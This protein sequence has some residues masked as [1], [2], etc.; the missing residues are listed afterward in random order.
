MTECERILAEG[1]FPKDFL[2]EEIRNGFLIT[3]K[4]KKNW[5]IQLDIL[6][7]FDDFCKKHNLKYFMLFGSLIGAVRHKGIIPWDDDIDV[8]MIKEDYDKFLKIAPSNFSEPYFV[9]C[10]DTQPNCYN[11][12]SRLNNSNTSLLYLPQLYHDF[13]LGIGIDLFSLEGISN[14]EEGRNLLNQLQD[15]CS[16]NDAA[17]RLETPQDLWLEDQREFQKN[18][19]G[20]DPHER[21]KLI[22]SLREKSHLKNHDYLSTLNFPKSG[23]DR[24]V[25]HREDFN[26]TIYLDFECLPFK[27]PVPIG[28]DRILKKI[29]GDYMR[30]PDERKVRVENPWFIL[31]PDVPYKELLVSVRQKYEKGEPLI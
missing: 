6:I 27:V 23:F 8:A 20:G 3:E 16:L 30:F 25:F 2:K 14:D 31:N 21:L 4:Q 7:K 11:T 12:L 10:N 5:L 15:L 28:Y 22:Y 9:R 13:D 24:L 18:Y 29:Y 19:S 26:E 17:M 1:L